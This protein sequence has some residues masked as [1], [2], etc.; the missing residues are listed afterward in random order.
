ME[1]EQPGGLQPGPGVCRKRKR[2]VLLHLALK[3]PGNLVL[4]QKCGIE[5]GKYSWECRYEIMDASMSYNNHADM[6]STC[7]TDSRGSGSADYLTRH[8][9]YS[10]NPHDINGS[11]IETIFGQMRQVAQHNLSATN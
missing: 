11:V 10:I 8:L 5:A 4:L 6:G 1:L 2:K 3:K 9:G 7:I